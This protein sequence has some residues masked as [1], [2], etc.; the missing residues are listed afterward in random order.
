[1]LHS[2]WLY[3][4]LLHLVVSTSRAF[5]PRPVSHEENQFTEDGGSDVRAG[6]GRRGHFPSAR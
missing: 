4:Y 1:L 3:L 6:S 5:W 2:P